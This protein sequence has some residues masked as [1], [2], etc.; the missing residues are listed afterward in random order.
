MRGVSSSP[1]ERLGVLMVTGAYYPELSGGGLQAR[2]VVQAL[3][4]RVRFM[5]LTTSIQPELPADVLD[6]GVPVH[7]I[8][9]DIG[10]RAS[11][12]SAVGKT[13]WFFAR[14]QH[15]FD[16]VNVHGFSR[17]S[18]LLHRLARLTRKRFVLTLQTGG[19]D[20]PAAARALG[21]RA[22]HA[23]ADADLVISVSPGL[24]RAYLDDGLPESKLRRVANAVD[25]RR[26]RPPTADERQ[27]LRRELGLPI[28]RAVVLFVGYFSADKRPDV[29]YE[30]W[31]RVD[32]RATPSTLVFVGATD[33]RY[34]EVDP[35]IAAAIRSDAAAHGRSHD[36]AFVAPTL[37]IEKYY[38]AADVYVLPSRREGLPIALLEAMATGLPC[39]ATRLP[40]STD[41]II[42]DG[43]S[44]V[45]IDVQDTPAYSAALTRVLSDP[46]YA[47]GLGVAAR[48]RVVERYSIHRTAEQWLAAYQEVLRERAR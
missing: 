43:K 42:D 2:A 12:L 38:R 27:S 30:A 15:R 11:E 36:V 14:A 35:A 40:G 7:R 19:H 6:D 29:L 46:D 25:T 33:S 28:D 31:S 9:V 45:L 8:F 44:G 13:A 4:D 22:Y 1:S 26:F 23:Y 32:R 34:K 21:P 41:V 3:R 39:I 47:R 5:V 17:K 16:I 20:E 24:A 37:E 10:R 18:I 48:E